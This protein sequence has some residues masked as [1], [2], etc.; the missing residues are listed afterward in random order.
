MKLLL[1]P[2]RGEYKLFSQHLQKNWKANVTAGPLSEGLTFADQKMIVA[3]GGFGKVD[4]ALHT[5]SWLLANKTIDAVACVGCA[6][7]LTPLPVGS[8]V[9]ATETIEH[10]FKTV[11]F[12]KPPPRFPIHETWKKQFAKNSQIH[13]GPIASG[14][15]DILSAERR[16]ELQKDTGAFAVAWE[17]A[18]AARACALHQIPFCEVRAISD[19]SSTDLETDFRKNLE[20]AMKNLAHVFLEIL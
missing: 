2:L 10:D 1:L 3:P 12:K 4:M 6:G 7:S 8:V 13:W 18:G 5:Q 17:G 11:F 9:V 19:D 15:E 20:L 14:D 16:Q